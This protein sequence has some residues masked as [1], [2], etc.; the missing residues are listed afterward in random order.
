MGERREWDLKSTHSLKVRA[1]W[2][3][4]KSA[5]LAVIVI[6][7]NDSVLAADPGIAPRDV[8]SLVCQ[9]MRELA[10]SLEGARREKK[11][12]VGLQWGDLHE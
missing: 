11:R 8:D 5:A 1:E 9:Q 12:A 4:T 3:R 6:R 10:R 2:L 7:V